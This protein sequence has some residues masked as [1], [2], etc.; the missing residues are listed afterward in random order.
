MRAD[1][2]IV[3]R[4]REEAHSL[5][6]AGAETVRLLVQRT[7]ERTSSITLCLVNGFEQQEKVLNEYEIR[8]QTPNRSYGHSIVTATGWSR[9]QNQQLHPDEDPAISPSGVRPQ[10]T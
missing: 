9:L 7:G 2:P 8:T 4:D 1:E 6:A 3:G 10:L 5:A